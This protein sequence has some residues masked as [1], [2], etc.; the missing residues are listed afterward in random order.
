MKWF[1]LTVMVL[2][3]VLSG[4]GARATASLES[5]A[6]SGRLSTHFTTAVYAPVDTTTADIYFTDLPPERWHPDADLAGV[7]GSLV[8]LHLFLAPRAGRTPIADTASNVV[9]RYLAISRGE[10]GVYSGGGFLRVSGSPGD[11]FFGGTV[12]GASATLT[13]ASAGFRDALGAST[14]TAQIS[15]AKDERNARVLAAR[16]AS[17]LARAPELADRAGRPPRVETPAK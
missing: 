16:V 3:V 1:L 9:V 4:C 8:H 7:S 10:V 6:G 13:R 5:A 17:L 12:R 14:L 15:A 2:M 11:D